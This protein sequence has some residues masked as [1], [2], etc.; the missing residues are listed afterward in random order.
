MNER[1]RKSDLE[2]AK[3]DG[4]NEGKE[5]G[6]KQGYNL[7]IEVGKQENTINIAK[8]MLDKGT[9]VNDISEITGLTKEE[10]LKLK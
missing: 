2:F 3:E 8:K 10:I 9:P 6:I 1:I 7:G 4:I 5:Q